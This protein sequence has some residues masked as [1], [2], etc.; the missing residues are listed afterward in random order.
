MTLHRP[1]QAVAAAA[2]GLPV[3]LLL[4][5]CTIGS[6]TTTADLGAAAAEISAALGTAPAGTATC[7]R[8]HAVITP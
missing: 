7:T 5:Y 8:H 2:L 1:V 4:G 6:F 3:P